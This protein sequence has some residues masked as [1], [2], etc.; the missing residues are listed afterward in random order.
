MAFHVLLEASDLLLQ[1]SRVGTSVEATVQLRRYPGVL[2]NDELENPALKASMERR[3]G[4]SEPRLD[5]LFL[6]LSLIFIHS[7]W[8]REHPSGPSPYASSPPW[9]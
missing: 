9:K 7:P 4:T 6:S 5:Q 3:E 2:I 1:L 8:Y